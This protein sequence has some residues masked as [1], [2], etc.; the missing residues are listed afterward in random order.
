M[1][2]N[3]FFVLDANK[4]SFCFVLFLDPCLRQCDFFLVFPAVKTACSNTVR[5]GFRTVKVV[6]EMAR[7]FN[8]LCYRKNQLSDS[9]PRTFV[10]TKA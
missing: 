5:L 4:G 9:G 2:D 7:I 10:K 1:F 6:R 3:F 8:L